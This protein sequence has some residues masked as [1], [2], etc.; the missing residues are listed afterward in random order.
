MSFTFDTSD[1]DAGV[2]RMIYEVE[3]ETPRAVDEGNKAVGRSFQTLAKKLSGEY[4]LSWRVLPAQSSGE[5]A[6][7][8][9]G[10]TVPYARKQE[11]RNQTVQRA[12]RSGSAEV[13]NGLASA[14]RRAVT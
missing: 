11:R 7:G 13:T 8:R 10:P 12:Y 3:R 1:F 5:G 6:E 2:N 14:W 9:A 4:S